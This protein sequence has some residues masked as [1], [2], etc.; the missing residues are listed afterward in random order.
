MRKWQPTLPH[1]IAD[2]WP[3]PSGW[4]WSISRDIIKTNAMGKAKIIILT[5]EFFLTAMFIYY[6]V[7]V[8]KENMSYK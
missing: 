3:H 1:R 7:V 8:I 5:P 4:A 2:A 6:W